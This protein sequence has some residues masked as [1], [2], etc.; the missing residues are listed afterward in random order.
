[1]SERDLMLHNDTPPKEEAWRYLQDME[2]YTILNFLSTCASTHHRCLASPG[3][4]LAPTSQPSASP[5]PPH[6]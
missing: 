5:C 3:L 2:L 4:A 6:P 1:M